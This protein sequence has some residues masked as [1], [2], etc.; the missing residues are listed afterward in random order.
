MFTCNVTLGSRM[1]FSTGPIQLTPAN[2][3]PPKCWKFLFSAHLYVPSAALP[4]ATSQ[5]CTSTGVEP[6]ST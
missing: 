3:S 6:A 5:L 1:A 2:S 4:S